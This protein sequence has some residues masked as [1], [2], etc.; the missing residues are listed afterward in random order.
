M[1]STTPRCA[2]CQGLIQ[3]SWDLTL[4]YSCV[5]DTLSNEAQQIVDDSIYKRYFLPGIKELKNSLGIGL[6]D[7]KFLYSWRYHQLRKLK[8]DSFPYPDKEYWMT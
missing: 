6:N 3:S 8:P 7:S 2:S 1:E 5:F 4:C